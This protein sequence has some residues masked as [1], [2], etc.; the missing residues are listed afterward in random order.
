L[1]QKGYLYD[2]L[3]HDLRGP[4]SVIAT[5][6][7]GLLCK[8]DRY[9]PVT[10]SQE[11]CLKRIARN[12]RRAQLVLEEILDV[13]RS[14]EHLFRAEPFLFETVVKQ[15]LMSALELMDTGIAER[16]QSSDEP[17]ATRQI[18]EEAGITVEISGKYEKAPF[19]HDKRKIAL[20]LEN[21]V[22]NGLKYRCK[23]VKVGISGE[24]DATIIVSDDGAGIPE[25]EQGAV[26]GRFIQLSNADG[27]VI[28]GLGLGLYC[29]KM[30]VE[31]MGGEIG[32]TSTV[33]CGTT[34]A[35]RIP[36]VQQVNGK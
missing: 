28:R 33:G 29:V 11:H 2:L 30:L 14:E 34:F 20:I 19:F 10:E 9:G 12:T 7:N 5:T 17:K 16:L 25:Q 36:P 31:A 8:A 27:P 23:S 26:Y 24:G 13:A 22:S 21:L 3:V 15:S 18:L 6:A 4:L 32:L 35:V 1:D